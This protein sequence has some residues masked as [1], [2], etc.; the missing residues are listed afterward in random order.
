MDRSDVVYLVTQ[1][2]N[3]NAYGVQV[4]QTSKRNV[5]CHV[6]SVTASEYFQGGANGMKPELRFTMF[7]YDYKGE[8]LVE[9]NGVVYKVYRTYKTINDNIELYVERRKGD[10]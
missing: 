7:S 5:F 9:Y 10:E 8:S 1:T 6:D 4:V 3:K 2:F